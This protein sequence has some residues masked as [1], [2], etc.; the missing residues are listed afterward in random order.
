MPKTVPSIAL[1]YWLVWFIWCLMP[2][3][4][5]FQL[6]CGSLLYWWRKPE[7]WEKTTDLSKVT[8]NLYL[9]MLY[10]VHLAMSRFPTHKFSGDTLIAYV[11][12]NPAT[13]PERPPF[14]CRYI[15]CR[16]VNNFKINK[17]CKNVSRQN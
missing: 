1:F 3:K 7:Y 5:I 9:I 15:S 16:I 11:I 14:Y 17:I 8:N 2:L 6:Y 10:G 12:V 4:T 13:I